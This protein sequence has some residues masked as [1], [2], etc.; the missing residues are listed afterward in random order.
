MTLQR[1]LITT[2]AEYQTEFWVRV[3]L[4]LQ[5]RGHGVAFISYDDRSTEMLRKDGF[6]VFSLSEEPSP[7]DISDTAMDDA[8]RQ[9]GLSNLNFWFSHERFAFGLSDSTV[10]RRK[11][12]HALSLT[13]KACAEWAPSGDAV[14]V[15]ELG[16]FLSVI[17]SY[18]AARKYGL[19]NWFIEPS[20]FK[21][22]LFFLK[23]TFAAINVIELKEEVVAS[24]QVI[25]YLASAVANKTIVVPKKDSHQY[26]AALRKVVNPRNFIRLGEKLLDKYVF[27]KRQEF[28]RIGWHVFVHLRMLLNSLLLKRSYSPLLPGMRFVYYPL[29]VPGDMALTLRTPQYLDQIALIDYLARMVPSTH[30]V[31]IKEHPAMIGAMDA[32][33]IKELLNRYDNLVIIPPS[34]NNYSVLQAAE[35]VVSVNSKSGAEAMLLNKRVVVLGDAFYRNSSLVTAL[36]NIDQLPTVLSKLVR[37]ST[38]NSQISTKVER[39]FEAVWRESFAGELY[40]S[41]VGNIGQFA[42]ALTENVRSK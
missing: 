33:R 25:D 34:T 7:R 9:Y 42:T 2:L 29:H 37:A 3:G 16:G 8:A 4:E 41:D 13:S 40:V 14:L 11:L 22:R 36:D 26:S 30:L 18:F 19:D 35:I 21:G 24:P 10:L 1:Y 12:L 27:K 32:S 5:Q 20:F 17:G 15:Q 39:Y 23:N 31:I 6:K 38:E 28:G